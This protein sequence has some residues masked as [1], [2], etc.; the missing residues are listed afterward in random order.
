MWLWINF[1][2]SLIA[3]TRSEITGQILSGAWTVSYGESRKFTVYA[4]HGLDSYSALKKSG[5]IGDPLSGLHDTEYRW[6][7][8]KNWTFTHTF[9]AQ[10]SLGAEVV[11][12]LVWNELDT[13]CQV[14]FN[15]VI[16]GQVSNSFLYRSW[17]IG[18]LAPASKDNILK[19]ECISTNRV[20]KQIA[21]SMKAPPPP[22]CWPSMFHGECHINL[23]RTTQA[24]FGW[25]WGPAFPIQGFWQPPQLIRSYRGCR[26]GRGFKFFPSI[27]NASKIATNNLISSSE[28]V[29]WNADIS[30]EVL[31]NSALSEKIRRFCIGFAMDNLITSP[32]VR[33]F[34]RFLITSSADV[35]LTLFTNR[36]GVTPWWPNRIVTGPHTYQLHLNLTTTDGKILDRITHT[37]GFRQ[38]E[39][40]EVSSGYLDVKY[41]PLLPPI[42]RSQGTHSFFYT[43]GKHYPNLLTF[44]RERSSVDT[45]EQEVRM[46]IRRLHSHPSVVIWATDNE[47]KQAVND[48]WYRPARDRILL[49]NFKRRFVDLISRV[50]YDEERPNSIDLMFTGAGTHLYQ[51]RRCLISSPSN[52]IVTEEL[53]GMDLNPQARYQC[54][55]MNL[56]ISLVKSV[57][58]TQNFSKY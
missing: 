1:L 11:N 54:F 51:P 2:L 48:G 34:T 53:K 29:L 21:N 55:T 58:T 49:K 38:F 5:F 30:V 50:I 26:F 31:F 25:D 41:L 4:E 44:P 39:L 3:L 28:L 56:C 45:V 42:S 40:V 18:N 6:V 32:V 7:S 36:T 20:A 35:P 14:S 33:C 9:R 13:F 12:E 17:V 27:T 43:L 47:V 8:S 46:Q 22:D 15:N 57:Y 52:G 23:V 37:V 19:L 24:S 16:L 10:S